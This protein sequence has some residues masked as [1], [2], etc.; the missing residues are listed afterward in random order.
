MV[1]IQ[2]YPHGKNAS[3]RAGQLALLQLLW[4]T[5]GVETEFRNAFTFIWDGN[6]DSSLVSDVI[7]CFIRGNAKIKLLPV[8]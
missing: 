3:C 5:R 4:Q 2:H 1:V 6:F 8:F 7:S